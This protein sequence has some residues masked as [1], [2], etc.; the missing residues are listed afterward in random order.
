PADSAGGLVVLGGQ[1][2]TAGGQEKMS[3]SKTNVVGLD[4]IVDTYGA[5]TARLYLLSDSPPERDLEW[6]AT[7]IEGTWRYV[8]RLWRLVSEPAATLP[9]AGSA[10]P[11]GLSPPLVALRRQTHKTVA[12]VT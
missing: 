8:N 5:D 4:D 2:V 12:A 7:G 1:P 6:T 9:P 11:D 3:K 10:M